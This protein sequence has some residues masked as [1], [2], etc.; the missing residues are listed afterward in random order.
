MYD[1][2]VNVAGAATQTKA[3]SKHTQGHMQ[4]WKKSPTEDHLFFYASD[5]QQILAHLC[6]GDPT[7]CSEG[8]LRVHAKFWGKKH[9]AV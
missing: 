7:C 4:G 3:G 2:G 1:Q 6:L 9:R 5:L 8:H